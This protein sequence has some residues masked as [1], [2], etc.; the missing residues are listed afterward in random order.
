MT[1]SEIIEKLEIVNG[2][3][4]SEEQLKLLQ[5]DG[6]MCIMAC[7]GSGKALDN[8]H[9][10]I[11]PDGAFKMGEAAIG[12]R[13]Y[14]EE[15][16]IQ[17]VEAVYPQG[18]KRVYNVIM[19]DGSIIR[20]CS[21]HIWGVYGLDGTLKEVTT[22]DLKHIC[23]SG[24]DSSG[25][26]DVRSEYKRNGAR[27]HSV[28]IPVAPV[29]YVKDAS[30]DKAYRTV[31]CAMPERS[32][33]QITAV[34]VRTAE[35]E[36]ILTELV[37]SIQNYDSRKTY[38]V[39]V[40]MDAGTRHGLIAGLIDSTGAYSLDGKYVL[41]AENNASI[42][43]NRL[44]SLSGYVASLTESVNG[45]Y[46]IEILAGEHKLHSK[47]AAGVEMMYRDAYERKPI[48]RSIVYVEETNEECEMT[49]ISVTGKNSLYMVEHGIITH[50]TTTLINLIA[51]RLLSGEI[52]DSSRMLCCT[53]SKDG[54]NEMN[55]RLKKLLSALGVD[56]NVTVK[57]LH[58][59]YYKILRVFG[60]DFKVITGERL[61]MLREA[62][63]TIG[64]R[65]TDEGLKDLDSLV[66]FQINNLMTDHMLVNSY[67]WN[68]EMS[69]SEYTSIRQE[70]SRLKRAAGGLDF[71]D[72]QMYVY[73]LMVKQ[74]RRD[75]IAYCNAM[76]KYIY[77]DEFQDTSRIQFEI[78]R[79]MVKDSN[80]LM[81]IGDDDQ[82][83]YQW[84][85][86]DP[87]IILNID[88]YYDLKKMSL[89][90]NYRCKANIVMFAANGIKNN[91][92]RAPKTMQYFNGGGSI[93]LIDCKETDLNNMSVKA[94]E[95]IKQSLAEGVPADEICILSRNNAQAS[96]IGN[97]LLKDGLFCSAPDEMKLSRSMLFKDVKAIM[98]IASGT[99]DRF[100]V[101]ETLWKLC[102][103]LGV[104]GSGYVSRFMDATGC[105]I[106]SSLGYISQKY[107]RHYVGFNREIKIVSR[108]DGQVRN[109]INM[110]NDNA[111][112]S[113]I[114]LY[115]VLS[116]K[117]MSQEQ[118]AHGL[119]AMYIDATDFMYKSREMDRMRIG[120]LNYFD[121]M[122]MNDGIQKT[123][124]FM[125]MTETYERGGL[126]V[127]GK[128]VC[129]STIHR[130]KGR[131]WD[132][133]II[134]GCDNISF[135]NFQMLDKMVG[136]VRAGGMK[137]E[138]VY[139]YIDGERRLNYVAMTRARNQ[140]ALVGS[141]MDLSVFALEDLGIIGNLNTESDTSFNNRLLVDFVD[142][143]LYKDI[144]KELQNLLT[145][146]EKP[147]W[148]EYEVL[149][150]SKG[151]GKIGAGGVVA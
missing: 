139:S 46:V 142:K 90:T 60:M 117:E 16:N 31:L 119:M 81:V 121:D 40:R 71:D 107:L 72:M 29:D 106:E 129:M 11:G 50:N 149:D 144:I 45:L 58:A 115:R 100:V 97:M 92:M 93:K 32:D 13:I 138:D 101:K 143:G 20:S 85:G 67:V 76:W 113:L 21:E 17:T 52:A 43:I 84:R 37:G 30:Y 44:F 74:E 128:K 135:P 133:V 48:E 96:L 2:H 53:Y 10:L 123:R 127:R 8:E 141:F 148:L 99:F 95:Y 15:K 4:F 125:S 88:G 86:A 137:I 6:G 14:D 73:T 116:D 3:K 126:E 19:S 26:I 103:M 64:I 134:F 63:K 34:T 94:V 66:S 111:K 42:F 54:A 49:C 56:C 83:I 36:K 136:Y 62:A 105:D 131:E 98:E 18:K 89:S 151:S 118:K 25:E 77:L 38:E 109:Q 108:I 114:S 47:S 35:I 9:L 33:S 22:I 7:A 55:V 12:D 124:Q 87:S 102:N 70:F 145:S 5:Q 78:M 75:V 27:V 59:T 112:T 51:K 140:L 28:K 120:I 68:L 146:P 80:N 1:V 110:L 41:S 61:R 104:K 130:A 69:E 65:L 122:I 79:K 82:C 39:I 132:R 23:V 57:T 150:N 24:K 91:Y 147:E